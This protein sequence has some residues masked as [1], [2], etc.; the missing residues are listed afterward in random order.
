MRTILSLSLATFTLAIPVAQPQAVGDLGG[1]GTSSS[2]QYALHTSIIDST[3]VLG[4][5]GRD[6]TQTFQTIEGVFNDFLSSFVAS[7]KLDQRT[8]DRLAG[9]VD[10]IAQH[11]IDD[12]ARFGAFE[13]EDVDAI[14]LE[15][16]GDIRGALGG[17]VTRD[18]VTN[19]SL[20]IDDTMCSLLGRSACP[21]VGDE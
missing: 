14:L 11:A 5:I 8:L 3:F 19:L 21:G 16:E 2:S 13:D 1:V 4:L 17:N 20:K 10:G 12:V 9:A 18:V 7:G 15:I 6:I